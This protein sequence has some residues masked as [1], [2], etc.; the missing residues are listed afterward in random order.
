MDTSYV[1]EFLFIHEFE[2]TGHLLVVHVCL[3]QVLVVV[4][5]A[6]EHLVV[7]YVGLVANLDLSVAVE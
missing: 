5:K 4:L 6:D 3:I 1:H 7:V 2:S